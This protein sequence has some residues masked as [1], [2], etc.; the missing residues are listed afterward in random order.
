M[1]CTG[2]TGEPGLRS[3]LL[4][5]A[6]KQRHDVGCFLLPDKRIGFACYVLVKVVAQDFKKQRLD[7]AADSGNLGQHGGAI[8]VGGEHLFYGCELP[9]DAA[10]A[11]KQLLPGVRDVGHEGSG[12]IP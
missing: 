4:D 5:M 11:G 1:G 3:R 9:L 8:S 12:N 10:G 6:S 7:R 2:A